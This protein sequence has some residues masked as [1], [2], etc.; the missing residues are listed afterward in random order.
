MSFTTCN[1]NIVV[2]VNFINKPVLVGYAV[3]LLV[4]LSRFLIALFIRVTYSSL[5]S[6]L[7]SPKSETGEIEIS[8]S[9]S[10]L[11]RAF[12]LLK[13]SGVNSLVRIRNTVSILFP[14]FLTKIYNSILNISILKIDGVFPMEAMI[15]I[16]CKSDDIN[17][18]PRIK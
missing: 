9:S 12:I 7:F 16:G 4:C 5:L 6:F 15:E 2:I 11:K 18:K 3:T 8:S 14:F 1:K 13:K 10:L 17:Q